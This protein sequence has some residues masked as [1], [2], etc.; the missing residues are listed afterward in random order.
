MGGET[1][2]LGGSEHNQ[3]EFYCTNKIWKHL[4]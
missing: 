2:G 4:L 1:T 3:K